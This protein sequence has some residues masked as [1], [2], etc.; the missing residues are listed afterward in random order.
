MLDIAH[1]FEIQNDV[2]NYALNAILNTH[3]PT[4]YH[5]M[6]FNDIVQHYTLVKE[7]YDIV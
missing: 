1:L 6:T 3:T 5:S 4:T 2:S 7:L